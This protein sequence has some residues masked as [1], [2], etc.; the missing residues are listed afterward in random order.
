MVTLGFVV[1]P[2]NVVGVNQDAL[3]ETL[4]AH[5]LWLKDKPNEPAV[6]L[7]PSGFTLTPTRM[8]PATL[9]TVE[10]VAVTAAAPPPLTVA[11]LSSG[12]PAVAE[13][14]TVTVTGG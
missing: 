6:W 9:T 2:V 10:S 7:G 1:T 8:H 5:P 4:Q 3:L 12:D 14:L 13:T 11:E